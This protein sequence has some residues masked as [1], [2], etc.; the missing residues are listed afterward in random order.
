MEFFAI[1]LLIAIKNKRAIY[2]L[3]SIIFWSSRATPAK[4]QLWSFLVA[5]RMLKLRTMRGSGKSQL[6]NSWR[7]V[8]RTSRPG[9]Q[10]CTLE[11]VVSFIQ[12]IVGLWFQNS[13]AFFLSTWV[14]PLEVAADRIKANSH[15]A[16]AFKRG[17]GISFGFW[18]LWFIQWMGTRGHCGEKALVNLI[19]DLI[20]D[21][22]TLFVT[23]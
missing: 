13:V 9:L 20:Q 3:K 16:Q 19:L 10:V 2:C 21:W 22:W 5:W 15:C 18:V 1:I 4:Q 17:V 23:T 7:R 12:Q 8:Y 6:T 11:F 14:E